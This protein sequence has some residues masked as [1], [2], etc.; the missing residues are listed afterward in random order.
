[1]ANLR[2]CCCGYPETPCTGTCDFDTSYAVSNLYIQ[3][4]YVYTRKTG[5]CS[6]CSDYDS[7]NVQTD[8]SYTVTGTQSTS[9]TLTRVTDESGVACC[10]RGGGQFGFSWSLSKPETYF[11]CGSNPGP[12]CTRDVPHSGVTGGV[13]FC[14]SVTCKPGAGTA[15]PNDTQVWFHQ[16]WICNF[17]L[18]RAGFARLDPDE[19]A[20]YDCNSVSLD[21]A[22]MMAKGARFGW[23]TK[24]KSLDLLAP[25]D[26]VSIQC[27]GYDERC[28]PNLD[29]DPLCPPEDAISGTGSAGGGPFSIYLIDEALYEAEPCTNI[30]LSNW[31]DTYQCGPNGPNVFDCTTS[32]EADCDGTQCGYTTFAYGCNFP[33]IS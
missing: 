12:V 16:L 1:M 28:L 25:G 21:R 30:E 8:V 13:P 29:P 22:M 27:P 18:E 20:T 10:Y 3:M 17:P 5:S 19:C 14:Y 23:Y 32:G 4:N 2:A 31:L 33:F 7:P 9:C 6:S 26:I 24:F 11:C 15:F